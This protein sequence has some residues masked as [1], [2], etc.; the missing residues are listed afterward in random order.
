MIKKIGVIGAGTMGCG[1]AQIAAQNNHSVYLIDKNSDQLDKA[2]ISLNKILTRLCEKGKI[3]PNEKTEI[4]DR[5]TRSTSL[6]KLSD[7]DLV[8][9]AIIE[10]L[11]IK[12]QVLNN[13]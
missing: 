4:Q 3:T 12:H 6:Q 2:I 9:E 10:D 13:F 11:K 1:I 8:I 7:C 5:I